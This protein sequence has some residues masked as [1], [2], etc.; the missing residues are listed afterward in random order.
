MEKDLEVFWRVLASYSEVVAGFL[1]HTP[2]L[3][4]GVRTGALKLEGGSCRPVCQQA[5]ALPGIHAPRGQEQMCY[6]ME[7]SPEASFLEACRG[8]KAV[9]HGDLCLPTVLLG[10]VLGA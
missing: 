2:G 8:G 6:Q 9:T 3:C 5:P 7:S 1:E 10:R 4:K